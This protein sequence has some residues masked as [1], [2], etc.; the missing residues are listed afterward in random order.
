MVQQIEYFR[1]KLGADLHLHLL[2]NREIRVIE[3]RSGDG[4]AAEILNPP[5][6]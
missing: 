5:S 4:I 1:A 6:A 3:T 2:H